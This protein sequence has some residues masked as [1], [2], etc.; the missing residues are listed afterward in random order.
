[1]PTGFLEMETRKEGGDKVSTSRLL[2][3]RWAVNRGG[4]TQLS[5]EAGS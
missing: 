3:R 1:M 2:L 4:K 5:Q